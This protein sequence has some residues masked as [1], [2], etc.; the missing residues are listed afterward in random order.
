M[1]PVLIKQYISSSLLPALLLLAA[2][3]LSGCTTVT[4]G[5][6]LE[7]DTGDIESIQYL[8]QEI[9]RMMESLGYDWLPVHDPDIGHPVK[10]AVINGQYRMLF[11][12]RDN[13]A[14]R[15]ET[16]IR[17]AGHHTGLHFYEVGNKD[18]G[19]PALEHY[20]KLKQRLVLEFGADNVTDKHPLLAP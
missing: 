4:G 17:V 9:S 16:H 8:P 15:V 20:R 2:L 14:I 5:R 13:T 6:T 11:Q 12:A 7:V 18:P 1:K 19:E 3:F 10:V